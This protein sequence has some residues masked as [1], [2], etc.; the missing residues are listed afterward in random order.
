[1]EKFVAKANPESSK[2]T[3]DG[4]FGPFY[5][6]TLT[7]VLEEGRRKL[8]DTKIREWELIAMSGKHKRHELG[9]KN[10]LLVDKHLE[11]LGYERGYKWVPDHFQMLFDR[12]YLRWSVEQIA[13]NRHCDDATVKRSTNRL[14]EIL[15][16]EPPRAPY[17]PR[18]EH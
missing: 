7:N 9:P 6:R 17:K 5:Q 3:L 2:V 1:M 15:G 13:E 8:S 10:T 11:E 18:S 16:L 4:V 12:L 14:I